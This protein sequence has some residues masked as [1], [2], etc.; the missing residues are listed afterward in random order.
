LVEI[1][2]LEGAGPSF[3]PTDFAPLLARIIVNECAPLP[4]TYTIEDLQWLYSINQD[5][6]E[7]SPEDTKDIARAVSKARI[8]GARAGDPQLQLRVNRMFQ[9][10]REETEKRL[11]EAQERVRTAEDEVQVIRA[12]K[13][14]LQVEL[15][16]H[17][18]KE[19]I[20][21]ARRRL[22]DLLLWRIPIAVAGAVVLWLFV[23]W[24]TKGLHARD[25]LATIISLLFL[26]GYLWKLTWV[27]IKNYRDEVRNAEERARAEVFMASE[28]DG[29]PTAHKS[30]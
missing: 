13:R 5:V 9:A 27:P 11:Q 12:E 30:T 1:L 7:L 15:V 26:V 2:A 4:S 17:K 25:V 22:R 6:A 19:L 24:L 28:A 16:E 3:D 23:G 14:Q 8:E 29:R 10:K 20:D 18:T 21:S